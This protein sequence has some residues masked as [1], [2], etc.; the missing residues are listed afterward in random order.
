[1][2]RCASLSNFIVRNNSQVTGYNGNAWV[3]MQVVAAGAL[4]GN[5]EETMTIEGN[6]AG[7]ISVSNQMTGAIDVAGDI[8]TSSALATI[9]AKQIRSIIANNIHA[10]ISTSSSDASDL[11]GRIATRTGGDFTGSLVTTNLKPLTVVGDTTAFIDI[12][13]DL[14]ANITVRD[15]VARESGTLATPLRTIRVGRDFKDDRTISIGGTLQGPNASNQWLGGISVGGSQGLKGQVIINADN[16]TG[17][18]QGGVAVTGVANPLSAP[19]YPFANASL[20]NGSI[21]RV[22]FNVHD[23]SSSPVNN[24]PSVPA[25]DITNNAFMR[26][27]PPATHRNI[28][29]EFDGPIAIDPNM[30]SNQSPVAVHYVIE[31]CDMFVPGG[32]N[33]I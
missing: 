21:G 6:L 32:S 23:A 30:P 24:A 5:V 9:S 12:G 26:T 1:L 22:P 19:N 10:N 18:W 15:D 4:V 14:D 11:V 2:I 28:I 13:R 31:T 17:Q 27:S 33:T 29:I 8:G 16:T 25:T 3:D 7:T 20:G